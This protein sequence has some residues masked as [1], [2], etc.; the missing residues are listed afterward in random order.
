MKIERFV[1]VIL[2]PIALIL[3][4]CEGSSYP[5]E[6]EDNFIASCRA[7][8]TQAQCRCMFAEIKKRMSFEEFKQLETKIKSGSPF[9]SE[10]SAK[11]QAATSNCK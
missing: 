6:V 2:L 10:E 5:P 9:T 3:S 4:G 11:L 8:S 7:T 1:I